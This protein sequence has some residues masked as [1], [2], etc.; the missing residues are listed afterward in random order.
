M[1]KLLILAV[2]LIGCST[3]QAQDWKDALSK[4]ATSAAD[5]VTGGKLTQMAITGRW[6]YSGPGVK[7]ESDDTLSELGGS[8]L[9]S[10]VEKKLDPVYQLAG[11]KPG[12]CHFTFDTDGAFEALL[13]THSLNGT[14]EFNPETHAITL[15]FSK[16][17]GK[18]GSLT[19]HAYLSG[20]Q[21]QLVLSERK[22]HGAALGNRSKN[23]I[24]A[25]PDSFARKIQ[26]YR[27]RV[28][29]FQIISFGYETYIMSVRL[30][31]RMRDNRC[32][33]T[34]AE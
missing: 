34:I 13:G 10:S 30:V 18:L 33:G 4:A 23:R 28:Q 12:A 17:P 3:L 22:T 15:H 11:I 19:G 1:K 8:A 20:S 7:F 27:H 31:R 25:T 24:A 32:F 2:L 21:M 16:A 26:E 6:E 29:F 14:Y 9:S 5:K